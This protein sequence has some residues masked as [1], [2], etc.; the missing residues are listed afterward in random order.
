MCRQLDADNIHLST[1]MS[2]TLLVKPSVFLVIQISKYDNQIRVIYR[3]CKK[4]ITLK[5][6]YVFNFKES[7]HLQIKL[8]NYHWKR[9]TVI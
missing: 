5:E 2:W 4:A 3:V 1:S 7:N 9:F 8:V 6:Y